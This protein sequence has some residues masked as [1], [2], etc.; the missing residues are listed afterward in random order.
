MWHSEFEYMH[1]K[2]TGLY[3]PPLPKMELARR[4]YSVQA[5]ILH[6]SGGSFTAGATY[7]TRA[8]L[9]GG[10]E[11]LLCC[12]KP[13]L[14]L[15]AKSHVSVVSNTVSYHVTRVTHPE[16][17]ARVAVYRIRSIPIVAKLKS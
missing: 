6:V 15:A 9:Q 12:K 1:G 4:G 11:I 13:T 16:G 2:I 5:M 17:S 3:T 14:A 7:A 10:H 8:I